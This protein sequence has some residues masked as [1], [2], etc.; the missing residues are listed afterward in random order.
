MEGVGQ[1]VKGVWRG[2]GGRGWTGG[3][4]LREGSLARPVNCVFLAPL[5]LSNVCRRRWWEGLRENG[6]GWGGC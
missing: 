3:G 6:R 4:V 2:L 1:S 5:M